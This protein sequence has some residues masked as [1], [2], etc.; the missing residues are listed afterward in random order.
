[1]DVG[2]GY[3]ERESGLAKIALQWMIKEAINAGLIVDSKLVDEV[4]GRAGGDYVP[5]DASGV[6]HNSLKGPWLVLEYLPRRHWN[7]KL[8]PPRFEWIFYCK[9]PRTIA[10]DSVLHQ[11]V[12][13]RLKDPKNN[14]HPVNLPKSFSV[15]PW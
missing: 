15:E 10:D 9:R 14:Y 1:S 5:P 7:P 12:L 3:P 8:S 6:I 4:L 2:G 13:D 11:S